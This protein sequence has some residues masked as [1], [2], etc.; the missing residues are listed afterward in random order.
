M[1]EAEGS[2]VTLSFGQTV[3]AVLKKLEKRGC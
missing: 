1:G 3:T 2:S